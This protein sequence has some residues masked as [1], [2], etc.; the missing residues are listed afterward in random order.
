MSNK[1]LR[2]A[3][4]VFMAGSM[5]VPV[6]PVSAAPTCFG[7]RATIVGTNRDPFK[8]VELNG[9]RRN[10]VIISL[11]GSDVI[12]GRGGDDLICGG[13]GDDYIKAGA[14]NDKVKGGALSDTIY[15]GAGRDQ[16]WGGPQSD[17]LIGG[18]GNDRLIGGH[19]F[20]SL[21]GGP[22]DD[23]IDDG[24]DYDAAEFWDS[25][26]GIEADLRAGT[27]AGYGLDTLVSIEGLVGS[28][29]DDVLHGDD[30]SNVIQGGAG[31][32]IIHAYASDADGGLDILRSSGGTNVLDGGD[33]PDIA[34][35]N[36]NP[37]PVNA[38]LATG[39]MTSDYGTDTLLGIEHLVGSRENDTLVGNDE[40][41]IIFGSAGDDFMD[42]RQGVDEVAF[43]DSR[44]PVTADLGAGTAEA[45]WWGSDTFVNFEN[46]A[47]SSWKDV[48]VGDDGDN[49]IRGWGRNDS[50]IGL[51]GNDQLIGG[52]GTDDAD[53][54]DGIDECEAEM[55]NC[56]FDVPLQTSREP[57][58]MPPG[59][60]AAFDMVVVSGQQALW[61]VTG[62]STLP[63]CSFLAPCARSAAI[64]GGGSHTCPSA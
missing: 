6:H 42:G 18:P 11:A 58:S 63:R 28:N 39:T 13:G 26:R 24:A 14:G 49:L 20:E 21:I 2:N 15:G 33:G 52:L 40:D 30:F 53:G 50:L 10:D 43:D 12:N 57:W 7:K 32:D 60:E 3:A 31:D 5:L 34:S 17:G 45:D 23:S 44:M 19:G 9:T 8:S 59:V 55:H 54:G 48:L 22:G 25:P 4:I 27:A 51:G 47:G 37:W 56:E 29:H 38:D 1:A 61:P 16:L 36:G 46:M 62:R 64:L 35:Y 41:N